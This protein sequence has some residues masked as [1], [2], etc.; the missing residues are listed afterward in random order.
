MPFFQ[1]YLGSRERMFQFDVYISDFITDEKTIC[2]N[3]FLLGLLLLYA[4]IIVSSVPFNSHW[5]IMIIIMHLY[6]RIKIIAVSLILNCKIGIILVRLL[7]NS[8]R[9]QTWLNFK[10]ML[11]L[12]HL[13]LNRKWFFPLVHDVGHYWYIFLLRLQSAHL[14]LSSIVNCQ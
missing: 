5:I 14:V 8:D 12:S 9:H 10:L 7:F 2:G 6:F 4:L 13:T 11:G 3:F 1:I